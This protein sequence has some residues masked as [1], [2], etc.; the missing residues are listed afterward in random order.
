MNLQQTDISADDWYRGWLI[1]KGTTL[2]IATWAIH[3]SDQFYKDPERF[4]PDRFTGYT[5]LAN[6][7]A[8][9]P[10]W[11]GR[12]HY[13]YGA[14]RRICPGIHLAER[15]IWRIASKLLWAFE[16]AE[17]VDPVTSE[18]IKLDPEAYNPGIL[19][20]PLPFKVQIKP[21]SQKH[22]ALIKQEKQQAIEF[23]QRYS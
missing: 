11:A 4:N 21:R 19:Q 22:V 17:P 6:D 16:F 7:Y 1:P 2:F 14:G 12:D 20:A 15:N 13:N 9:S 23:L 3:H 10:D 18:T 8:G 5:R